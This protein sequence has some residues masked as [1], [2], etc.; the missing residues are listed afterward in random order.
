MQTDVVADVSFSG[1]HLNLH[2]GKRGVDVI[3]DNAA[4]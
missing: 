2:C 4:E 1:R 3:T